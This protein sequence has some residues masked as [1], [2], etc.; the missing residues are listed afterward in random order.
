[1]HKRD[2]FP[3][4]ISV[5]FRRDPLGFLRQD[6]TNTAKRIKDNPSLQDKSP[7][8]K[9]E[10][11]RGNA[12]T[13]IRQ[14]GGDASDQMEVLGECT[15]QFGEYQGKS[16]RWL[17]ENDVGYAVYII[18]GQQ[19]E[20]AAGQVQS[21]GHNKDSLMAFV[22][23]A[24]SFSQIQSLIDFEL[25]R[26]GRDVSAAASEDE[27]LVGF[28]SRASST[29]RDI[30]ESRSDGYAAFI[31]K[32]RCAA[33]TKMHKLQ[34]Y[35]Q[36]RQ[37]QE[38]SASPQESGQ[39]LAFSI[40][41]ES[42]EKEK[43]LKKAVPVPPELMFLLPQTDTPP[44]TTA[45]TVSE[46]ARRNSLAVISQSQQELTPAQKS[47]KP[48]AEVHYTPP[49]V[50]PANEDD[51][52][53]W[54]CSDQQ[55]IWMKTELQSMGLWPGSPPVRNP[56]KMLSLWRQPPQPELIDSIHDLPSPTY[57]Q[58]HPFFIWM[59][60]NDEIMGRLRNNYRFPC[61]STCVAPQVVPAG[62]GRPRVIV[63]TTGQY[64]LLSSRLSCKVCRKRWFA[65]NP[66]WLEKLPKRFINLLPA[67]L[68][69]K[70]AICK[71]VM[72]EL[73]RTGNSPS[74]MANQ[75]NET[76]HL[77]YE[78]ANLAYLLACQNV[79]DGEVGAYGQRPISGFVR[80]ETKPAP[81]G[82]YGDGDGWNGICVS[83]H[84]LTD[85]L[86]QEFK[87]QEAPIKKM[88][89]G[90]FGQAFRSDHTRKVA[91][92]VTLSSGTMSSYVVMNETW[93]IVS[94]VMLQSESDMSLQPMYEGLA[95][96]YN[97]VGVEKAR[98]QWVDRDCCAAFVVAETHAEEH[99]SWESWKTTDAIVAEATT[100][101]LVNSCASRSHYNSNITIKLDLS[102]CMRRFLRECVSEHHPL[103]G[104][105]AQFLSAAFSVVD[106]EDLQALKD[107]YRFCQIHP[108]NP[109]KQHIRQHCR[110]R[111]PHPQELIKRVEGVFQH[112]HLASDPNGVPLFKPSM[113]KVW[114]IQR[115]HILRGCLS[116]PEVEGGILYRHGGTLQLNHVPGEG[117]AVPVWIPI[118]GTSQQE[119][120][121]F[122]QAQ[123]VTGTRVSPELFQA[124]GLTGVARWNF[125]RLVDLKLPGV[126]LPA[127]FNPALIADLNSASERVMGERK[128]PALHLSGADTG[129]MFGLEYVEPE[130][131][132]VPL[133]WDEHKSRS[134]PAP[135]ETPHPPSSPL[136]PSSELPP[137]TPETPARIF[138]FSSQLSEPPAEDQTV[139]PQTKT[140][141]AAPSPLPLLSSPSSA[142]TGPI[143]T[144]GRV[145]VL[146]H[147][148]WPA[149]MKEVIDGLLTKHRGQKDMLKLVDQDY[150]ALVQSSCPDPNSMLHP[151]TEQHIS[152][153]IK[154]LNTTTS[155]NTGPEKLQD[156]QR[157]WQSLTS[158]SDT[159]SVPVVQ[160][161]GHITTPPAQA[162]NTTL[163]REAVEKIVQNI[164]E[165][166]QHQ[167]L[168]AQKQPKTKKCLSCG[169][170]KSRYEN[171]GSS[172]HF[173][174]QQGPVRYFYCST[175]VF[176]T[177]NAEGLTN[178]KMVFED[179][180][181]TE[182]FQRE[183]EGTQKRV[184]EKK[185]RKRKRTEAAAPAGRKCSFCKLP[186]KQGPDSP[187]IHT[188]FPGVV[189][190]YIYCPG[191][192]FSLYREMGMER[193]M[194]WRSF[195]KSPFYK[196][197][198]QRW[199]VDRK[200]K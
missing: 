99:L 164:L 71:S 168:D 142:C 200:K 197:E 31:L 41:A 122:H 47:Q 42:D 116:D 56:M 161:S 198:W 185:Q 72:D 94:W 76:M 134:E 37:Q 190:K 165:K 20:E 91:R 45:A 189:G 39:S 73:R 21:Q 179:F 128:Y 156:R 195:Q 96:R 70:K 4:N 143:K 81:F 78:R 86:L 69:S 6:P 169:Q 79:M 153:Y 88:M 162:P 173:F 186:L 50:L 158:G 174:Y 167:Q 8:V 60:E 152:R 120:Y 184:E 97:N 160:M 5:V 25:S 193:K 126:R 93:M 40:S 49:P 188:N 55:R 129:E 7:A 64:Y 110:I 176:Q 18:K 170:P 105:F 35:L 12:L 180:S 67:T 29:W 66:Q 136:T 135:T 28:G 187:H 181:K 154:L 57:F 53:H 100:G 90:T 130:T 192:V 48:S 183:L 172:I 1:M 87:L 95:T 15:L 196:M 114:R 147:P 182:F 3:G 194:S 10:L 123:W 19:R 149:P 132:P 17:L 65:D 175:K 101:H 109:T 125:Q 62:M 51:I 59:P 46:P 178:P 199:G 80:Q 141:D 30:W 112:F 131:R 115:V 104:S 124:Q 22:R 61:V 139:Q 32:K 137:P 38:E 151:T 159:T 106:Q 24:L 84:H 52:H 127:V 133:N 23:Y 82:E 111:I 44:T 118:R 113:L 150:A 54:N 36:K 26:T 108:P 119:G 43:V 107:A 177:Y 102:H 34:Q 157:L 83:S 58:L 191:K 103:Y 11:V 163:T 155:L 117:A 140:E 146:D 121:H 74:D 148:R 171:D 89:Q 77:K 16:F 14:R 144:G 98:V 145:F 9:Q 27:E 13:V 75:I 92:K 63:G 138:Q 166:Q 33:G 85:C 2:L 68:T